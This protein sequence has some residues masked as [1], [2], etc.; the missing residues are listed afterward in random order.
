MEDEATIYTFRL[1][2]HVKTILNQ[3]EMYF[4]IVY[5]FQH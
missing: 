5:I 2:G 4:Y 3:D 1:R